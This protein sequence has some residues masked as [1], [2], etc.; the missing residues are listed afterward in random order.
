ML[1][2][3]EVKKLF[4]EHIKLCDLQK[5]QETWERQS[6][7][8]RD[9]WKNKIM[10]GTGDLTEEEMQPIIRLLDASAKGIRNSGIEPAGRPRGI[11]QNRWYRLFRDIKNDDLLKDTL[12]KLFNSDS[13]NER[14]K[15][16]NHLHETCHNYLA[17][18]NGTILND[19][20]FVFNPIENICILSLS[21]RYMI[22]DTFE[23]G[24]S[25]E[26]RKLSYGEQI[27]ES[28]NL[29]LV[30]KSKLGLDISNR[31]F[32]MAFYSDNP[33][34]GFTYKKAGLIYNTWFKKK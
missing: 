24:N 26:L 4:E 27:I 14:I 21:R 34:A 31:V 29:I 23:L 2:I 18:K 16:I 28:K 3:A 13:D 17:G 5:S 15:L 22:I 12:Y 8:F 20:L 25:E 10:Q 32:S 9:F 19:I 11:T 6:S 30:L 7:Q 1:N 33:Q